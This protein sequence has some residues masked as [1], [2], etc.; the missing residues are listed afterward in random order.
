[1]VA[2]VANVAAI[3]RVACVLWV[4]YRGAGK[5]LDCHNVQFSARL[6]EQRVSRF[7]SLLGSDVV[8]RIL[9][10]AGYLLGGR[11]RRIAESLDMSPDT[12]KSFLKSVQ[13]VGLSALEDRRRRT[14]SFLPP[15]EPSPAKP[16]LYEEGEFVVVDFG[17][18]GKTLR[19]PR[20]NPLQVKVVLLSLLD[21]GLLERQDVADRLG[22]TPVHACN[23]AKRLRQEGVDA[24]IDKRGQK[25]DYR[26]VPEVKAEVIQQFVIDIVREGKTSGRRL[27]EELE[28]RCHLALPERSVRYHVVRLG[29]SRIR[30]SL[31]QLL[32]GVK[33][34]STTS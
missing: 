29:L 8:K 30:D 11:R 34:N 10:F 5:M 16:R 33:K 18:S 15:A 14:S 12:A 23:R 24:L 31:P 1:M 6:S 2:S 3:G 7:E 13:Q 28:E 26:F 4:N 20:S 19:L 9:C 27:S 25:Q 22:W 21:S 17:L 32:A